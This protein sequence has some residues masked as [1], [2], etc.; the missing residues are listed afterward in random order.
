MRSASH[1]QFD[2]K[3]SSPSIGISQPGLQS[4]GQPSL[5]FE[6][7][8]SG[9]ENLDDDAAIRHALS[10]TIRACS[11]SREQ[12]ADEM[13]K[14]LATRV[15]EKMLNSYTGESNQP[16]RFPA[17]WVRAFCRA[18]GDDTLLVCCVH[19]AGL[20][21]ITPAERELLELGRSVVARKEIDAKIAMLGKRMGVDL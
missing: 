8:A 19:L 16:Y 4:A 15:T 20:F 14:L 11:R 9:P 17:A 7:R 21:V 10:S 13:T 1:S 3:V 6:R 12:I 5:N 18:T 2:A